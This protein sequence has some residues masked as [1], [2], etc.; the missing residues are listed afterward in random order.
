MRRMDF[1]HADPQPQNLF[2]I[3]QNIC[4]VPRMQAAAREQSFRIF[5]HV[6]D[7]ELIYAVREADH[8]GRDVVDEDSTVDATG[9]QVFQKLLRGPAEFYDLLKVWPSSLYEFERMRFEHL[10]RLDMN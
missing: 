6:V 3:S 9:V 10:Q 2:H 8:F 1:D 5:L 4:G 7:D